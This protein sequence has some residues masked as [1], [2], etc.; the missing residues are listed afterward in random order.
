[1]SSWRALAQWPRLRPAKTGFWTRAQARSV[2]C[3][4][5][6]YPQIPSIYTSINQLTPLTGPLPALSRT[7][8]RFRW[9]QAFVKPRGRWRVLENI[10]LPDCRPVMQSLHFTQ[11]VL[12]THSFASHT[13]TSLFVSPRGGS[14]CDVRPIRGE[15]KAAN[16]IQ[17]RADRVS[18]RQRSPLI[19]SILCVKC[20]ARCAVSRYFTLWQLN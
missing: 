1:M 12:V 7:R 5:S 14:S 11:H 2:I 20:R 13:H 8:R 3:V 9:Q 15:K 6:K 19:R 10:K 18:R 4:H 17:P 16:P